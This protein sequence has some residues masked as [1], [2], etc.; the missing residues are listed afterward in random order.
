MNGSDQRVGRPRRIAIRVL[1]WIAIPAILGTAYF[2]VVHRRDSSD[3][4]TAI[5]A[6][7]FEAAHQIAVARDDARRQ[8]DITVVVSSRAR[9]MAA[10]AASRFGVEI[11]PD[12][13]IQFGT[14]RFDTANQEWRIAWGES[15]YDVVRVSTDQWRHSPNGDLEHSTVSRTIRVLAAT[16]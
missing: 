4:Q 1:V 14:Q 11:D 12:N 6:A 9:R 5:D 15:P 16:R 7:A 2:L 8:G 3:P 13:D 10:E